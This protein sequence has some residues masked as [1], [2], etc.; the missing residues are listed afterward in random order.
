MAYWGVYAGKLR[1][2]VLALKYSRSLHLC[3]L[4]SDLLLEISK[5]LTQPDL[6]LPVPLSDT[7]LRMRGFN[8]SLEMGRYLA[9]EINVKISGSVLY[10]IK[11]NLPQEGLDAEQRKE[12]IKGV[13]AVSKMI[14]NQRIWLI[15]DVMT[16]GSTLE[17]CCKVLL[18]NGAKS[19]SI[20]F[21]A[22]TL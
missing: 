12:N 19:V 10:R 16:T 15:D 11:D 1:D 6:I 2:L 5:C 9:K 14:E 20:L 17:E 7:R 13:F 18:A 3:H 22:R 21:I 4:F 8:Q